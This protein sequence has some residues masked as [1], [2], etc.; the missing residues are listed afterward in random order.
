M[1]AWQSQ[2]STWIH[3]FFK[4][5]PRQFGL[6]HVYWRFT[7][8]LGGR[9]F[10]F[11]WAIRFLI[12][13]DMKN[14][15][16]GPFLCFIWLMPGLTASHV[17]CGISFARQQCCTTVC[18]SNAMLQITC[19]RTLKQVHHGI[20]FYIRKAVSKRCLQQA[21][22]T[23]LM[24]HGL[25]LLSYFCRWLE[26]MI[27]L[28]S[29]FDIESTGIVLSFSLASALVWAWDFILSFFRGYINFRTGQGMTAGK[30]LWSVTFVQPLHLESRD[31]DI[32]FAKIWR[33]RS[34]SSMLF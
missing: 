4:H 29:S 23:I 9:W 33:G 14:K 20:G 18:L 8:K 2:E 26:V 6:E 12:G 28:L 10:P 27:P 15:K 21:V 7:P 30:C 31:T 1:I 17:F 32:V 3:E 16:I 24:L 19:K 25:H 11:C 5:K 13:G 22:C 34:P